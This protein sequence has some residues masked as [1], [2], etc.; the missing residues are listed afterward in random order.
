[1]TLEDLSDVHARFLSLWEEPSFR[2]VSASLDER[3]GV[4]RSA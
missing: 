2:A 3:D 1:L 4:L